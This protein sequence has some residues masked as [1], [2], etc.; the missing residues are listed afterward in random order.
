MKQTFLD[1][2]ISLNGKLQT[3]LSEEER[4]VSEAV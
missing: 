3:S 4:I 2:L 1:E